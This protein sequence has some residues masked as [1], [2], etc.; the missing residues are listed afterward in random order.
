MEYTE[1]LNIQATGLKLYGRK[2]VILDHAQVYGVGFTRQQAKVVGK[3]FGH[4]NYKDNELIEFYISN[5][6]PKTEHPEHNVWL[7]KNTAYVVFN[8]EMTPVTEIH[9]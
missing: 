4:P 7:S 9:Q 8:H 6:A 5:P 1:A 3:T 2:V